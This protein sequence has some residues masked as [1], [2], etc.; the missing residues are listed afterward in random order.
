MPT[1]PSIEIRPRY[2]HG[3]SDVLARPHDTGSRPPG[4]VEAPW[5]A[6]GRTADVTLPTMT[7]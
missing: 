2:E 1:R 5:M 6:T 4:D 7:A 3:P